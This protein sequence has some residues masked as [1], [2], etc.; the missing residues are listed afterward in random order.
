M[1]TSFLRSI[2]AAA[3]TALVL[4]VAAQ[5]TTSAAALAEHLPAAP[6]G[7]SSSDGEQIQTSA[8]GNDVAQVSRVFTNSDGAEVE[9]QII[10]TP[11]MVAASQSAGMMFQNQMMLDQ[12]N[13]SNPD[14]QFA[15]IDNDGW[16]GWTVVDQGDSACEATAFNE[17]LVVKITTNRGDGDMLA[18]FVELVPWAAL[19]ALNE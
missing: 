18:T 10:G 16:T 12:M 2:V 13:S 3:T 9:L 14:K 5:Q 19:G 4:P 1:R 8:M 11:A 17:H 15:T 7:W 6:S